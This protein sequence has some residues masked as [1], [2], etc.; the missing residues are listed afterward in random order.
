MNTSAFAEEPLAHAHF[1]SKGHENWLEAIISVAQHYRLSCSAENIRLASIETGNLSLEDIVRRMARMAGLSIRFSQLTDAGLTAWR[2]PIVVQ[3]DDGQLGVVETLDKKGNAGV[4][5]T[6]DEG[7]LSSV[8]RQELLNRVIKSVILRPAEAVAD[9]RVDDYIKPYERHWF[10]QI[11]LRDMKPYGHVMLASLVANTM[12]LSGVLFSM[13]VYDRVVPSESIATLYVLFIGVLI[14][15]IFDFIMRLMR[16]KVID[17]LGKRADLRISDRVFGHAIRLKNSARPKSTGTFI[18]QLRELESVRDMITSSTV[19]VIADL[20]FFL[21]FLFIF[22]IIAGPLVWV[23][24]AAVVF[25]LLPGFLAQKKLSR[26]ARAAQRESSLRNAMLVETVQGIEDI[27]TL[28]AEQRFQQ[29]WNHYT[30]VSGEASLSMRALVSK[31]TTWTQNVQ[32]LVF[33]LVVLFGAPM[34]MAGDMS[35]GSLVAASILSSRMLS[36]MSQ[37]TQLLTR[38]QQAKVGLEGLNQLMQ[39]PVDHPEGSKRVHRALI[40]GDYEL[41][42]ASFKYSNEDPTTALHID[43]LHIDPGERI[44]VLGKNG[45]GKSTLLQALAGTLEAKR[46]GISLDGIALGH[47]DPADVRRDVALLSQNSRLFHGTIYDNITLGAADA[48]DEEIISALTLSGAIDFI[49]KTPKGLDYLIQEGGHGLSGGQRQSLL[50]ARLLIRQPNV[51]LLD[52]PTAA[53]DEATEK[54]F[55]NA[56]D[57]WAE[58]RTLVIATHRMSVLRIVQRIIVVDNGKIVLDDARDAALAR[59]ARVK[60]AAADVAAVAS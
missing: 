10:R 41:R 49:R 3:F 8:P 15:V 16:V 1:S 39:L 57:E 25:M 43:Q 37:V 45:A 44:A 50:L 35:T 33:A 54:Q 38:W 48:S 5:F 22:W 6:G 18:S 29:K 55:L 19:A 11:V 23:P 2:L 24:A 27:K 53:M 13:Q 47:L 56:L 59:L 31:L 32:T 51:L 14:A 46:G 20:P 26:L 21:F 58:Q 7:L 34:V 52:E 9:E 17:L 40:R 28:Q 30:S 12:A 60:P 42:D 4:R 36:P